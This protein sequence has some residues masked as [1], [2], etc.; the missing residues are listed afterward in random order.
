MTRGTK[1]IRGVTNVVSIQGVRGGSQS[2][3]VGGGQS[4]G[5]PV[6]LRTRLTVKN[7]RQPGASSGCVVQYVRGTKV[8]NAGVT[9]VV[10]TQDSQEQAPCATYWFLGLVQVPHEAPV[11]VQCGTAKGPLVGV[12]GGSEGATLGLLAQH[13]ITRRRTASSSSCYSVDVKGY[14]VDVKG[15][16]ADVKGYDVDVYKDYGADV[17]GYG[18]DVK[19]YD[20]HATHSITRRA[21]MT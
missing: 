7:T 8:Q 1:N 10:N 6:S 5:T 3:G 4:G 9:N 18:A 16:D 13:L 17:K 19:G 14:G 15:Y 2:G 20:H 12:R 11:G 21:T